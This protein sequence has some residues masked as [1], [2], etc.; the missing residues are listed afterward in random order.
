MRRIKVKAHKRGKSKVK[1]HVRRVKN[2]S[3]KRDLSPYYARITNKRKEMNRRVDEIRRLRQKTSLP[4]S[5]EIK[6]NRLIDYNKRKVINL[7][8]DIDWLESQIN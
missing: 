6:N 3:K 7:G 2:K 1:S 5:E 8:Q 4:I